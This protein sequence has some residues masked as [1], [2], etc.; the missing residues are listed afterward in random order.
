MKNIYLILLFCSSVNFNAL[1][2]RS[3]MNFTTGFNLFS[4]DVDRRNLMGETSWYLIDNKK[5]W[6]SP[7]LYDDWYNGT[8]L[9]AD[10]VEYSQYKVKYNCYTQELSFNDG[11]DSLIV[12]K[13]VAGFSI[14]LK[15]DNKIY[16]FVS[17][18][19]YGDKK[20]IKYYEVISNNEYGAYVRFN[21]KELVSS[22]TTIAVSQ[23]EQ[24][25]QYK[26]EYKY[27][28]KITKKFAKVKDDN[29]NWID[30]I[31][32]AKYAEKIN[33]SEISKSFT[34]IDNVIEF[35]AAYK[36]FKNGK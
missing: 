6:G 27:F 8:I 35:L 23:T 18:K 31:K 36:N 3:G 24:T 1:A 11:K 21:T 19:Q 30:L 17:G 9:M 13:E 32:D 34:S 4:L 16:N 33:I 20:S 10:S 22:S 2:Q 29:S 7:F 26:Y 25:F 28:N 15:E 5:V 14:N 12:D